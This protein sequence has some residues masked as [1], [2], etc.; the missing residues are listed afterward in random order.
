MEPNIKTARVSRQEKNL[1]RGQLEKVLEYHQSLEHC[2]HDYQQTTNH[3]DY[4]K[5]WQELQEK[6]QERMQIVSRFMVTK[7]NR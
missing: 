3:P 2:L 7:C 4:L 6:N 5:F 1:M